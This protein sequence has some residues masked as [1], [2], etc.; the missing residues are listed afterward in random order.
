MG[1]WGMGGLN[2]PET[3]LSTQNT[4]YIWW[5]Y[6]YPYLKMQSLGQV[7]VNKWKIH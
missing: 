3:I 1:K 2:V 5:F 6:A 7:C 4:H